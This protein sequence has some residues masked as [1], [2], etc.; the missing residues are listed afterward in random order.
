M[1][2]EKHNNYALKA[3]I[4]NFK[5]RNNYSLRGMEKYGC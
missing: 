1:Q 4:H 3:L 5:E 2:S